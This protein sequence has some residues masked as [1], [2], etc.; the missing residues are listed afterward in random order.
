MFSSY[1]SSNYPGD[2]SSYMYSNVPGD[3]ND[4]GVSAVSCTRDVVYNGEWISLVPTPN[5][6][7]NR[8]SLDVSNGARITPHLQ[9]SRGFQVLT[10]EFH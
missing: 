2:D 3:N 7:F 6:P 10:F 5:N 9:V 8:G 4:V 1:S